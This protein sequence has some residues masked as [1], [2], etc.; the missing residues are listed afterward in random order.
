MYKSEGVPMFLREDLKNG[1][2]LLLLFKL[3]NT[4]YIILYML[5]GE[6]EVYDALWNICFRNHST[7]N[8]QIYIIKKNLSNFNVFNLKTIVNVIENYYY[9]AIYLY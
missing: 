8:T 4:Y 6:Y 5:K 7:K 2:F 1:I 9:C 3:L